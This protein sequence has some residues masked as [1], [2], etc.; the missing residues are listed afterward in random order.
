MWVD[1]SNWKVDLKASCILRILKLTLGF[2]YEEQWK[3]KNKKDALKGLRPKSPF[4]QKIKP[5]LPTT[6]KE[7]LFKHRDVRILRECLAGLHRKAPPMLQKKIHDTL[8][9]FAES[10]KSYCLCE[11]KSY[12]E[13]EKRYACLNCGRRHR[14]V[15]GDPPIEVV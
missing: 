4:G 1:R 3:M 9:E 11:E 5:Q 8:L 13:N 12:V 10:I 2:N 6:K 15:E 7:T 14:R